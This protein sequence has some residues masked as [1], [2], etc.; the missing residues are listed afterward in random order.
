MSASGVQ[1][2]GQG[3]KL[4]ANQSRSVFFLKINLSSLPVL[5]THIHTACTQSPLLFDVTV[6]SDLRPSCVHISI[7]WQLQ[8]NSCVCDYNLPDLHV[9]QKQ[10]DIHRQYHH[11]RVCVSMEGGACTLPPQC[12]RSSARL[13]CWNS[14]TIAQ[15]LPQSRALIMALKWL[16]SADSHNTGSLGLS[17]QSWR[18]TSRAI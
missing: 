17:A 14:A 10:L 2:A 7:S 5:H 11:V 1:C 3:D 13:L 6:S 12:V 15:Y 4:T 8:S 18:W 9:T 16:V